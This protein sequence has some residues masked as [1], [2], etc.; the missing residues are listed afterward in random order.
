LK[1]LCIEKCHVFVYRDNSEGIEFWRRT[2][3]T[4]RTELVIF[5]R[6]TGNMT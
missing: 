4:E 2:G 5:S 3:W 1:A 6:S